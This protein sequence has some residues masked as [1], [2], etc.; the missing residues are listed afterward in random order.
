MTKSTKTTYVRFP[1]KMFDTFS[2]IRKNK[3]RYLIQS[4]W[5]E[6]ALGAAENGGFFPYE[7]DFTDPIEEAAD[8]LDVTLDDLQTALD[9]LTKK[10]KVLI[11]ADRR[12]YI[13]DSR[14]WGYIVSAESESRKNRP[15]RNGPAISAIHAETERLRA[16]LNAKEVRE[17]IQKLDDFD[18]GS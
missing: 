17:K 3:D 10:D 13:E 12:I 11:T 15:S 7:G 8:T 2:R 16:E 14:L 6:L 4:M 18:F 1:V 5:V 9:Y